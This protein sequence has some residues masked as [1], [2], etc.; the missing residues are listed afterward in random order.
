[1]TEFKKFVVWLALP[2]LLGIAGCSSK[3]TS[4]KKYSI[5]AM[6]KDGS[7]YIIQTDSLDALTIDPAADGSKVTIKD[8]WSDLIVKDGFYYRL[9]WKTETFFKYRV[10]G[11]HLLELDTVKLPGF[12]FLE[13]YHWV[14][15]DTILL[16]TYNKHI[17]KI[18]YTKLNVSD[19][20]L[21][22]GDMEIPA[23]AGMF[24]WMSIGFARLRK[25]RL[26]VGYTYHTTSTNGFTTSDTA[27]VSVLKYP[28]MTSVQV[29]KD[30]RS[31]YPGGIN[32]EEPFT[33][34]DEKGDFYY[35]ACPGIALG[36]HPDKPT[37]IY[38]IKSNEEHPDSS[39]FINISASAIQNH[40]YGIWY[41]GN[42]KAIVRSERK[43][44]FTGMK[45]HYKVAHFDFYV[46][47]LATG[48]TERL[49][50]PL[51]KGTARQCVIYKDGIAYIT[52]NSDTAGS[53]VWTYHPQTKTLKRGMKFEGAIDYILRIDE[54]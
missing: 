27:H 50:L 8:L 7:E 24:N 45:D 4:P 20:T 46:V 39:F 6:M 32:T 23:P 12:S 14:N 15:K 35:I 41:V 54:L 29:F 10:E 28:E 26:F 42:G 9:D 47:E 21:K 2:F 22:T 37:G 5:Y 17:R 48:K 38:R 40:A 53:Y 44:L 13:T 25:D 34:T 43:G 51:D 16:I 1:M 49:A 31:T 30:T 18:L 11:D 36:N 52:I 19:F 3:E 33:F